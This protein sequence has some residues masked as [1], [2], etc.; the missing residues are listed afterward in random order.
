MAAA[1]N[2]SSLVW[3]AMSSMVAAGHHLGD[4]GLRL[5]VSAKTVGTHK[6]RLM[7]KLGIDNTAD[8]VRYA[9]R[10]GLSEG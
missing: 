9:L 3:S 1:F 8:L 5:N 6:Q 4:I 2:A 7:Q 10:H